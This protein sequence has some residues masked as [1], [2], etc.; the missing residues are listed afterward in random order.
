MKTQFNKYLLILSLSSS[1]ATAG[2]IND[3][4]WG[5]KNTGASITTDINPLQTYRLQAVAGEDINLAMPLKGRKVKVAVV[6]TGIDLEHPDL[7]SFIVN[8][9]S[10]CAAYEA[11]KKCITP[12]STEAEANQCRTDILP[13]AENVY[14]ADC[15]GWSILDGGGITNTPNNIIGRPD[16]ID[17]SGHGTHVSGVIRSVSPNVVIIPVQVIGEGPNQPI[18]PFSIDL[19]PN[20]NIRLGYTTTTLSERISRG[21]IYAM[22][23]GAEVI[24]LSIGWP[25][26]DNSDII[27]EAISEAQRRGI[28]IVAAAGNDSTNSI[29]RPCQF[30]G[31]ICVGA[32]APDGSLAG[33]SN[34]GYGVDIAAPGV[35]IVSTVPLANLSAR[36]VGYQGYDALSGTSQATPF[37]TGVVAEMLSRGIPKDEIYPRLMLGARPVKKDLPVLVGPR[38]QTAQAISSTSIYNKTVLSGLLDMQKSLMVSKQPLILPADKEIQLINWDRK[39]RNMR[40][41][42]NLKN[43]WQSVDNAR[44]QILA[45]PTHNSDIEAQVVQVSGQQNLNSWKSGEEKKFSIDLTIKDQTD[46]GLSRIPSELSYQV[47]VYVNSVLTRQFEVKAE[48]IVNVTDTL[49]GQGVEQLNLF[50]EIPRGMKLS[51]IDEVL[52]QKPKQRD[53]FIAGKDDKNEENFNLGLV[54]YNKAQNSYQVEKIQSLKLNGNLKLTRPQYKI[55]ADLDG[56]GKVEYIYGIVEYLDKDLGLASDYHNH[57]YIFDENMNLKKYVLF[58]DKRAAL[59]FTFYWMKVNGQLRPTWIGMGQE[60][61]KKWDITDLWGTE[62]T[63]ED[64]AKNVVSK[65]NLH[66]YFLNEDFKLDQIKPLNEGERIVEIIQPTSSDAQQGKV[67]ALVAKNLGTEIKPS[68]LNEFSLVQIQNAQISSSKKMGTLGL[69]LNY[70]NL[71]D[72]FADKTLTLKS[73]GSEFRGLMWYGVSAGQQQRVT[74]LDLDTMQLTDK[75]IS[76]QRKVYDNA[77]LI[78]AGFQSPSRKGA[79]VI[80]NSELEYHDLITDQVASTSLG[81]YSFFGSNYFVQLFFP[82]TITN[83]KNTKEKWPALFTTESSELSKGLKILTAVYD[84]K[85][86]LKNIVS[87][88]KLRF[89]SEKGCKP[90]DAPLY[91]GEDKGYAMDYLCTNKILRFLLQY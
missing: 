37:V 83:S 4:M 67:T 78:K 20:E 5:L 85:G 6:D 44:I 89:K 63:A 59:P 51:L 36:V 40:F 69:D 66:M 82:I 64:V 12:Q 28:I 21:I 58:D 54:R 39:S 34:F 84:E 74:M 72:T 79:F 25:E 57:F 70:R 88:A 76:A 48:I 35:E 24:N 49:T 65:R 45:R 1:V 61:I 31:V 23:S 68:Y 47:F 30:K 53:Y 41:P 3:L 87:P 55:R 90:L 80:T 81:R 26:S 32:H 16:F 43:Y 29:L 62:G 46:A 86:Q 73:E 60:V 91:L 38:L 52:D 2:S 15:H 75:S 50:G 7:S 17:E 71:V 11:L 8:N 33:F 42:L 9:T 14:P 27:K 18:K 19:S 13:S 10:K 56:D 22:N 77:L